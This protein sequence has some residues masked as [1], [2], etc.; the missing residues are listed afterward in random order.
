MDDQKKYSNTDSKIGKKIDV[1]VESINKVTEEYIV[2]FDILIEKL[3]E[4]NIVELSEE[5][6]KSK[7][8]QVRMDHLIQ[9][10]MRMKKI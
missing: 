5:E 8:L 3:K 7:V 2:Y 1:Y 10:I 9:S 4:F 6:K